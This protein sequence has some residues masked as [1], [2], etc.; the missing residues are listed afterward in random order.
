[1]AD[2]RWLPVIRR[3]LNLETK[4]KFSRVFVLRKIPAMA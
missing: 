4:A 2:M 3:S 1:M